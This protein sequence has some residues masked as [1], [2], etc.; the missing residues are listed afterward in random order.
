[1]SRIE[2][3]LQKKEERRSKLQRSLNSIVESMK[4]MGAQKIVLFGS[5]ANG[6]VDVNSDLDLFVL[7]PS[8]KTGKEWMDIIYSTV[9]KKVASHIIAFNQDEFRKELPTSSFLENIMKGKVLYEKAA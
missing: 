2:E 5:L 4:N 8:A 6:D 9:E 3:I 7:M 1:M